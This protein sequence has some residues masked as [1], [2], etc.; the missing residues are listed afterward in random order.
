VRPEILY[1]VFAPVTSLPGVG[2]RIGKLIE[3][4][5]GAHLVGLYWHLPSGIIDRRFAPKVAEAPAGTIATITVGVDEHLPPRTRRLPYKVRCSDATG[6]LFLVFFH[7]HEDYLRR[8]LPPGETRVVSGTVEHY[9]EQIQITHPDHIGTL[10]DMAQLQAVEP[11][12]PLTTGLTLNPLN[13]A[14][15]A[16]LERAPELPE[17]LDGAFLG[18]RGWPGWL[19]ALGRAHSPEGEEDLSPHSPA[20][21]RLAYDELLANQLAL[22]LVRESLRRVPG[23]PV[24]GDGRLRAKATAALPYALTESQEQ[25]VAEIAADMASDSRMLRLLQGDVG[26]GKTIVAFLAMLI[27]VEAGAQA[28][29]MAPTEVLARQHRDVLAPLAEAVGLRLAL[30]TAR[31]KGK[32]RAKLLADLAEGRVDLLVGTHAVWPWW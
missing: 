25:A 14:I 9:G 16:A 28:A 1:P 10:D 29:L 19:E 23:R 22:A 7:A 3:R 5:A 6:D 11:V 18:E 4:L 26:S 24:S 20:R 2:P 27:A 32:P 8:A 17:W 21:M 30:L 15:R 13:K 31:D 12:Y